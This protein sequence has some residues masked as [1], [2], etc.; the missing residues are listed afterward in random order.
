MAGTAGEC[1]QS[2]GDNVCV[3]FA[4][5]DGDGVISCP[6]SFAPCSETQELDGSGVDDDGADGSQNTNNDGNSNSNS[7]SNSSNNDD[8]DANNSNSDKHNNNNNNNNNS[9]NRQ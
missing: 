8:D 6:V 7:N 4:A 5:R 2:D 3:P 9:N 1:K